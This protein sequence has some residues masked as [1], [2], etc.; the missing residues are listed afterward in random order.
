MAW[1]HV[2]ARP[3]LPAVHVAFSGAADGDLAVDVPAAE[4]AARREAVMAGS[5][6]WLR[7]V[8]GSDVVVVDEPGEHAGAH[9]DASVTSVPGAVLAVQTADCAGVLLLGTGPDSLAVAAA[10]A[11]WR[12]L[13]QGVLQ[14]SVGRLRAAGATKV[15][16]LLGPCIGPASYEFGER[17]LSV[18]VDRY[19]PSLAAT[20]AEGA[21]SLDLRAGVRIALAEAGAH[22]MV[23]EGWRNDPVPCTATDDGPDGPRWF[24][25]RARKDAGRQV[26]AVRIGEWP[27]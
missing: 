17:D 13:A 5:W 2:E 10:H 16:W 7:Q 26:A 6:T 9:A 11:G 20:T 12:G 21:P 14:E 1:R 23:V 3:G 15:E 27:A 19:G 8:H 25:W 4:L 22:P 24:S 18:L